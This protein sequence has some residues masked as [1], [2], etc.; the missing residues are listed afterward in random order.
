MGQSKVVKI[1]ILTQLVWK[2]VLENMVKEKHC[3]RQKYKDVHQTSKAGVPFRSWPKFLG[4][5][6]ECFMARVSFWKD[7]EVTDPE[8]LDQN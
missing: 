7:Y 3:K 6:L 2:V 8:R 5:G 4:V 1:K